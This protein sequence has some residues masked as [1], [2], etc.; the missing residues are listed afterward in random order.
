[1]ATRSKAKTKA[2][3]CFHRRQDGHW[4]SSDVLAYQKRTAHR[5]D[6]NA[7]HFRAQHANR[8]RIN[9]PVRV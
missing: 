9:E 7:L 6:L 8:D 3:R 5:L 2:K 4:V 1:M